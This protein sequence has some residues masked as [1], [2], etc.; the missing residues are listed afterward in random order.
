MPMR[1]PSL[2]LD[3]LSDLPPEVT[4]R[5]AWYGHDLANCDDWIERLSADEI[6][7][8][9]QDGS[10]PS[11]APRLQRILD[12]VLNGRGF[13][14]VRA[15]PVARWSRRQAAMA[16]LRIGAHLGNLRMQNAQGH[17]LGHGR[18]LGGRG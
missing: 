13:V 2:S 5:S 11:L 6:A 3:L 10:L 4:D 14:L 12:E 16:F 17:L 7:E 1:V 8:I 9:E 18:D 15:L